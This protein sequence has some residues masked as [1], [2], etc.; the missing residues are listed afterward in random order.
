[1]EALLGEPLSKSTARAGVE[2]RL[3]VSLAKWEHSEGVLSLLEK[4]HKT[5]YPTYF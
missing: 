4:T 2:L 5:K 1:M 3:V